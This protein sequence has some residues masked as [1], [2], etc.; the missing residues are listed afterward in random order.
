MNSAIQNRVVNAYKYHFNS[1]F[2]LIKAPGRI[3][4]IG[5]H[6]DYND[7][8]VFPAAIDHSIIFAIG[9][10]RDQSS[11][12]ISL[13]EGQ[14]YDIDELTANRL[15]PGSWMFYVLGV[16]G[17]LEKLGKETGPFNVVF[18]GDIPIGSGM[19]SSAALECGLAFGLDQLFNL[20]L[21]RMEMAYI[22]Q[23]AEHHYVGVKCGIMDQF[24]SLMGREEQAILLDKPKLNS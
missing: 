11:I 12:A 16:V 1:D 19:S 21:S 17:E 6:T 18:S 22:G 2:T 10:S 3:N 20:G 8:F 5:E 15:D 7:G 9:K 14:R 24:A 4:L 13:D 23:R